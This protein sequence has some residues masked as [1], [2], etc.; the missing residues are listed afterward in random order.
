MK[1]CELISR[2]K[3]LK[4]VNFENRDNNAIF[5]AE[6]AL[7][8]YVE[9]ELKFELENYKKFELLNAEKITPHFMSLVKNANKSECP[10]KICN[11]DGIPFE[12]PAD[13]KRHI[14]DYFKQIYKRVDNVNILGNVESINTFL[15][16]DIIERREVSAAKLSETEKLDLDLPLTIEELTASINKSNLK[17]APGSNGISNKFIKRYWDFFK[18]PLLK[19]ANY[20]F[21]TGRLTNSFRTADI[22][23]IPKKGGDLKKI[24]NWRPISLLNCF[25]KCI[26]RA[27]AERLKKYMNK[28][29]PCA[30]KGYANG[31]YC[32]EVLIGVIDS[33]ETCKNRNIK[34]ALLSLDI[35]KAFDSLS[36]SYLQNVFKFFNFGPNI[37]R[38]LTILSMN[39][40][41]RIVIN[42]DISTD[43][44]ELERGNAQ[45]DTISP[46]LF[47]LG[48]QI[49]LFKLEFD[50]QIAGLVPEVTLPPDFPPLPD[51]VSQVPPKVYA[52][53]DDATVL[54][55]MDFDTLVRI[56]QILLEFQILSGLACNV[57]K[58]TLMQFGSN[59]PVS[60]DILNLGFDVK[61]EVKLLGLKIES[62]CSNYSA[63]KN[64]I[65][66]KIEKQLR[67]WN[68]FDLSLPGRISVSKT[69]MYSQLNYIGCFLPIESERIINIE[70]RIENYVKG[71]LN[72]SKE[73]MT[74]TR[75]EGGLG[76]FS[77]AIF[78]GSQACTWAKRAQTLDDNWKLRLYKGSNGNTLNLRSKNFNKK[79]EPILHNI[80]SYMEKFQNLLSGIGENY[81]ESYIIENDC[82]TYGGEQ[83]KKFDCEFFGQE[84]WDNNIYRL[85]TLKYAQL[86]NRNSEILNFNDF[87]RTSNLNIAEDKFNVLRRSVSEVIEA[88]GNG[89]N[90]KKG[91]DILTF[92]NRF[93]KGS[94]PF[95]RVLRNFTQEEIPRNINTY[96][97]NTQTIIGLELGQKINGLWGFSFFTND[98]RIFL[99]KMHTNILGLNN[100]VAHFIRDHSP[101]CTFCRILARGDANDE[102]T[103]H[104]FYDCP[105]TEAVRNDFF[106]WA[107]NEDANYSISRNDLFLV[108]NVNGEY[109]CTTLIKT[110]IAKL[111]LKYV[112]D[113]R[114]RY[115]LPSFLEAK[116]IITSDLLTLVNSGNKIRR[117]FNDS[118]LAQNFLQG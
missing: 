25:Y 28:L 75:E 46:F 54:T 97:E 89:A 24:K 112:W 4:N 117:S 32:Q 56:R 88:N 9:K 114:N 81:K 38:W 33:I 108:Q 60:Q 94:K 40:A 30:Q 26:S 104:L 78:L 84:F 95:R 71:P 92:C 6:S 13:L 87:I 66:E 10:T 20:A 3:N 29:T 2:I 34:G 49:L 48:Y 90:V 61:D 85:G 17:S 55:R 115:S 109:N 22:K 76:L 68:R 27:F 44:F 57:E 43:I 37:S 35:Q 15:G 12:T 103:L 19:Y 118:G 21:T 52:M 100:R 77:I 58:T 67:F 106:V 63:S 16:E 93:K 70:N 64:D 8:N 102:S 36:H 51:H 14:G 5:R 82:F 111:F 7:S 101:I 65:E 59:E 31:R 80:A 105:T 1:K 99:F 83:R 18:Y 86:F 79:E 41:A 116:E 62:N 107:Y 91:V 50:L 47:N 53:A 42:S 72:I 23:L 45:G 98:F 69:F 96:A 110:I 73:R 39:R 11:D 113:C 74:L